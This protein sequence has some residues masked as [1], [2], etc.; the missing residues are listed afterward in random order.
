MTGFKHLAGPSILRGAE[1]AWSQDLSGDDPIE[2][3]APALIFGLDGLLGAN[4]GTAD[5]AISV[6]SRFLRYVPANG[7]HQWPQLPPELVQRFIW[8][9]RPDRYGQHRSVSPAT[10][11]N[12]RWAVGALL[13][14]AV[15]LGVDINVPALLG[16]PIGSAPPKASS[17]PLTAAEAQLVRDHADAGLRASTRSV[18]VGLASAGAS[19][20][21]AAA[22]TAAHVNLDA[23]TVRLSGSAERTNPLDEWSLQAIELHLRHHPG[24]LDPDHP[25]CVT[26]GLPVERAAHSITVRLRTVLIDAGVAG[27]PGVTARSIRLTGALA[28]AQER[29]IRAA[30]RF[31]GSGSLD[32]T[33][34]ALRWAEDGE[35]YA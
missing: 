14:V 8:A 2:A 18:A 16:E 23:A 22:V 32:R 20:R 35:Q 28:V 6:N 17:R 11:R 5:K 12:N 13:D 33:A 24:E 30:A 3:W 4:Q 27:Q 15:M 19:P 7:V 29:G 26:A 21:E 34:A 1:A 9:A 25:L 10:A 31:L